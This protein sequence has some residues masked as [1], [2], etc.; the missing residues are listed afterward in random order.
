MK[1]A[2]ICE[3]SAEGSWLTQQF[4]CVTSRLDT[5]EAAAGGLSHFISCLREPAE[6]KGC[7]PLLHSGRLAHKDL[8]RG[9]H[10]H[11]RPDAFMRR[12]NCRG[13]VSSFRLMILIHEQRWRSLSPIVQDCYVWMCESVWITLNYSLR[14]GCVTSSS[15]VSIISVNHLLPLQQG[16]N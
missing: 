5:W 9:V 11:T 12:I 1:A 2:D 4:K 16:A 10:Y 13:H 7:P 14:A 8:D 6:D 15:L 3:N